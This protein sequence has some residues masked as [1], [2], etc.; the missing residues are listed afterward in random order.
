MRM[1][2]N[3]AEFTFPRRRARDYFVSV[4]ILR[5]TS[6]V[7]E[8]DTVY[9][10]YSIDALRGN[11]CVESPAMK[12]ADVNILMQPTAAGIVELYHVCAYVEGQCGLTR[13]AT[14]ISF[15]RQQWT[16]RILMDLFVE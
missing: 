3:V 6:P 16:G 2:S 1:H 14:L 11:L 4:H 12:T 9:I 15:L 13:F 8:K 10:F 7:K 5:L